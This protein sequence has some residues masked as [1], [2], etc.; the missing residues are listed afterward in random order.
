VVRGAFSPARAWRPAVVAR[1]PRT[2]GR[3]RTNR[4]PLS[5][6]VSDFLLPLQPYLDAFA[7]H[8]PARR[9]GLLE[10]AMTP[11][12]VVEG[13]RRVF[14]GYVEISGKIEGF[15]KTWPNCRL[16]L[17]NGIVCFRN[18]GHFANA[19]IATEGSVRASGHSVVEL[20]Q[21]GRIQRVQAF[22]GPPPPLP[23][24]WPARHSVQNSRGGK[25]AA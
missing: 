15:H 17:A 5:M 10:Q 1:L 25:S 4:R 23:K 9:L 22:W 8:N 18:I 14:A 24:S 19:I 2:L 3:T 13:P 16:V 11:D 21:D 6:E 20:A 7:E 12:A